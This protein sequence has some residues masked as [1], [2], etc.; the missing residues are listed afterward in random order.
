MSRPDQTP[1][2]ASPTRSGAPPAGKSSPPS[3]GL[4]VPVRKG[5]RAKA[6]EGETVK[7]A[8]F[9][10][11]ELAGMLKAFAARHRLTP[12]LAVADWIQEAEVREALDRGRQDFEKGD[13]V[14][15]E[16]ALRRLSKW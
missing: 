11:P 12:S 15:H 7:V 13:V 10:P 1:A 5:G 3:P 8:L 4:Q 6:F 14:G 16:G 9:L 2:L